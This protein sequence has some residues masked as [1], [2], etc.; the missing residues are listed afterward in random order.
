MF[1]QAYRSISD[2]YL[3]LPFRKQ[4]KLQV[5]NFGWAFNKGD[6]DNRKTLIGTTKRLPRH[7]GGWLI[8]VLQYFTAINFWT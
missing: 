4:G 8:R 1:Y 6:N 3:L 5:L 7:L 2:S